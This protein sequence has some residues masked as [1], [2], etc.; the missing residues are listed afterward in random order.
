M[1]DCTYILIL[2]HSYH[3]D[4]YGPTTNHPEEWMSAF[5]SVFMDCPE[6]GC[7]TR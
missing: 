2:L 4:P 7:G 6:M 3:P 5:S 1:H